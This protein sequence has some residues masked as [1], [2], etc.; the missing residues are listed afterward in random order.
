MWP[1]LQVLDPSVTEQF[2]GYVVAI[3]SFAQI[4]GGPLIGYWSHKIKSVKEPI[5]I[6]LAISIFG[7]LLYLCAQTVEKTA[8]R[9]YIILASRAIIGFSA[10]IVS[11]LRSFGVMASKAEDRSRT[12]AFITGGFALGM[13]TGPAVQ[14]LFTSLN[15]PGFELFGGVLI[16]MYTAPSFV[17]FVVNAFGIGAIIS[18][19]EEKYAGIS[20]KVQV[21][22]NGELEKVQIP[23]YDKL[24]VLICCFTRFTQMFTYTNLETLGSPMAMTMFAL[25]KKEAVTTVATAHAFLSTFAFVIYAGFAA[26][27]LDKYVNFRKMCIG[28]LLLLGLFHIITYSYPFLPGHLKTYDSSDF[29]NN[30][31]PVG[32]NKDRFSWCDTVN[33]VNIWVFYIAY[34]VCIGLAFPGVNLSM[35]TLYTQIIGP[36]RQTT[37]Q[38]I[39]QM[40]GSVARLTGPLIISSIYQAYGPTISWDIEI[41]VIAFTIIVHIVYRKRLVPLKV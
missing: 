11:L 6:C 21:N 41:V 9:R 2:Y 24:A 36:R 40:F 20:K 7:N 37:L 39:Q 12:V 22:E 25:T 10:S 16:N 34:S 18:L 8:Y 27:K 31:E 5:I 15:Y 19:F 30:T 35:N 13:T 17:A 38:G 32:C 33:P 14:L 29:Y 26:K 28:G 3:Y 23:P 1:Y 4:L